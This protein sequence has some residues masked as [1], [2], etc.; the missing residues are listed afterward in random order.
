[1]QC[2]AANAQDQ[3]LCHQLMFLHAIDAVVSVADLRAAAKSVAHHKCSEVCSGQV[4]SVVIPH[5]KQKAESHAR[6]C[7]LLHDQYM[8]KL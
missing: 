5:T 2:N 4:A 7:L 6:F 3:G 8:P 1:M